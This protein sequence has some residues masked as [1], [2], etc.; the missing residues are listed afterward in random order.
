LERNGILNHN[1]LEGMEGNNTSGD[2]E[3][4]PEII[5]RTLNG[6]TAL[7]CSGLGSRVK[8][9][10]E[11]RGNYKKPPHLLVVSAGNS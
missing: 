6:T 5:P 9:T 8:G 7:T 3:E 1:N 4:E 11:V 2:I 10:R